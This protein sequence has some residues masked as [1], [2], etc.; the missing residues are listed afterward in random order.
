MSDRTFK[1]GTV[2]DTKTVGSSANFSRSRDDDICLLRQTQGH[3]D[4]VPTFTNEFLSL[5]HE[6]M[7]RLPRAPPRMKSE[8][9]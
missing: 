5:N 7:L 1:D 2:G 6:Q 3:P 9:R 8:Y 4:K